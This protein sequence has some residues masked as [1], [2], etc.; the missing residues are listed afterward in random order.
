MDHSILL[1]KKRQYQRARQRLSDIT[2]TSYES[3]F[4]IKHTHNSTAI[5]GNTLS[6]LETKVIL[7]DG[8]SIGG[9]YLRELYEV[10]NH[11]K[12]Y[13]YI[14][15]CVQEGKP[16]S[17]SIGKEIHK[18]LMKNILCGGN[19]RDTAVCISGAQFMPPTADS[20][21]QEINNFFA[22]LW[23]SK[24]LMDPISIAAWTHAEFVRIHPYCDG[25][26]RTARLL[27]NYQLLTDGFP[28]ISIAKENS[29]AYFK[30]LEIYAIHRNL[31][32]FLDMVA[33]LVE[34]QLD[35]YIRMS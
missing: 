3:D 5:E 23:G 20:L 24:C 8:I 18:I 12:A 35:I 14:K 13:R 34:Q 7:E 21:P 26:G 33:E 32:P 19:Y 4:E 29:I 22:E 9:K 11:R 27:M 1:E 6:L 28:A 31:D 2:L 17:E 25:N 10:V 16:L 15:A 30:A